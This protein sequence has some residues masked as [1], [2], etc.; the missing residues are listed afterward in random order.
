MNHK[1]EAPSR[2]LK[3]CLAEVEERKKLSQIIFCLY[4]FL[5]E[6]L[7]STSLPLNKHT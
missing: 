1:L 6:I 5:A 4:C 7:V 2:Y 3:L